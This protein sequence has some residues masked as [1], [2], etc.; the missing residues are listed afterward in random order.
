MDS[1][2]KYRIS[3]WW[4]CQTLLAF[5]MHIFLVIDGTAWCYAIRFVVRCY[6]I[7]SPIIGGPDRTDRHLSPPPTVS[8]KI[9]SG[10]QSVMIRNDL[11]RIRGEERKAWQWTNNWQLATHPA[12]ISAGTLNSHQWHT[13]HWHTSSSAAVQTLQRRSAEPP[14]QLSDSSWSITTHLA[15]NTDTD[16]I[17]DTNT[18]P[19]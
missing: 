15:S 12:L 5:A 19:F 9:S 14:L 8:L 3:T 2:P 11:I 13:T 6:A 10:S 4:S 17:T 16:K 7:M 1:W 18:A